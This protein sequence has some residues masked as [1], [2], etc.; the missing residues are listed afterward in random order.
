[1]APNI[2][3]CVMKN[4][5][6]D[7]KVTREGRNAKLIPNLNLNSIFLSNEQKSFVFRFCNSKWIP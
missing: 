4:E 5:I 2:T 3:M 6:L 1:M 7:D